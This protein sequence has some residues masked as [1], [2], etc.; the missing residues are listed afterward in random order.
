MPSSNTKLFFSILRWDL[1]I[2]YIREPKD[3][4]K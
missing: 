4:G 1:S 2:P 3:V